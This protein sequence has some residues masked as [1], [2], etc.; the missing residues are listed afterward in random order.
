[1]IALEQAR[2]HLQSHGLKQAVEVLDD[3]LD[4]A[5]SK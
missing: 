4:V 5:A 2:Q 1:M 3:T